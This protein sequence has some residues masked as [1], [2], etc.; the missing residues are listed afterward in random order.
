LITNGAE[1]RTI[2]ADD[3]SQSPIGLAP[4]LAILTFN[5]DIQVALVDPHNRRSWGRFLAS[6]TSIEQIKF[7][8]H[9][10]DGKAGRYRADYELS[11][12]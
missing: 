9:A 5:H 2:A 10:V 6:W 8:P 11:A 7:L 12:Q 4:T 3:R 1:I